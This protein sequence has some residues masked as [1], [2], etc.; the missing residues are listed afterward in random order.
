MHLPAGARNSWWWG[1][2]AVLSPLSFRQRTDTVRKKGA[3]PSKAT[4]V[5]FGCGY[6][7]YLIVHGE[8]ALSPGYLAVCIF[9]Q[10]QWGLLL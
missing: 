1:A 9:C 5:G 6:A 10:V 3:R 4:D 7:I 2:E 8:E